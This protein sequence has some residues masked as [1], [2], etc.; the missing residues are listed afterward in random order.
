LVTSLSPD[1]RPKAAQPETTIDAFLG[2]RVQ[3]RQPRQGFRAG[4]DSVMLAAAVP[5]RPGD[6]VCDLGAG[7]GTASLCLAARIG[8]L[9]MTG[10]E[11]DE[12]LAAL[13]QANAE[14]NEGAQSFHV[15][16]ADVLKRPRALKRQS[17]RHVLT[18]PPYH[19]IARGT[20][21]P[22]AAKARATSSHA[23]DLIAWLRFARALAHPQGVVTAILPPDQIPQALQALSAEGL[24][25]EIVPL[26]PKEGAPAK[27]AIIRVRINARAPLLMQPGIVLHRPDG[28][29]TEEAEAVLRRAAALTT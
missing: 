19:D 18:N 8:G 26:W 13:A 12:K 2:G 1:Q 25:V 10:V 16:V 5:A 27:R 4:L 23:S 17:F 7:V 20:R 9:H 3:V 21:A 15:V 22:T 6:T 11:I 28:K 29:P 14:R 24:G